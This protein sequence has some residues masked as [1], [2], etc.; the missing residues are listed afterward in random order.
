MWE[1]VQVGYY[2]QLTRDSIN[3]ATLIG[4][5]DNEKIK[6]VFGNDFECLKVTARLDRIQTAVVVAK[7]YKNDS[8]TEGYS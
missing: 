2:A 4:V 7:A 1:S 3:T 6:E 5:L 8:Y